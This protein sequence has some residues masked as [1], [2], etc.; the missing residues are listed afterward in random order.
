MTGEQNK[1][2]A[3]LERG[4][5]AKNLAI[6][7]IV[8]SAALSLTVFLVGPIY[9]WSGMELFT[10]GL[11]PF[12]LALIYAVSASV[13]AALYTKMIGQEEE[14]ILLER[15]KSTVASIL[16]ISED[17][18]FTAKHSL[19]NF[20]KYIPPFV[21]VLCFALCTAGIIAFWTNS[22]TGGA[23]AET[24][25][26]LIPKNPINLAFLSAI[27]AV[28]SFIGGIF[29]VGQS[30]VK[31]FRYLRPVGSWLILG[32]TVMFISA[33]CA[34]L[35]HAGSTGYEVIAAK[36]VF[37][38]YALLTAELLI[39]FVVEFYRPRSRD[40]EQRP[41]YESRLLSIFTEPGGVMRNIAESLD[42]QF[43]FKVSKTW[44]YTFAQKHL[45]PALLLW[46]FL[47]WIFT[48][49]AEVNPGEVGI[50][51]RFGAFPKDQSV[52]DPGVHLKLPWPCEKIIRV[53][54]DKVN[55]ITI[56]ATID[57]DKVANAA[58][59]VLWTGSHSSY[60]EE[61]PFLVATRMEGEMPKAPAANKDGESDSSM[62]PASLL[63]VSMPLYF[64]AKK[65]QPYLYAVQ[66]A[67]VSEAI[68]SIG[69][70]EATQ[71]FASTDF[72]KDLSYGREE[73][74]SVLRNLIQEKCDRLNMGVDIIS[75]GMHDA[76]PPVGKA[77]E[78]GS[79]DDTP[80]A[81]PNVAEAF[82]DVVCA[83][84]DATSEK[85]KAE[86]TAVQTVQAASALAMKITADAEA[87]KFNVTEVA[88]TDAFRFVSQ[89][90]AFRNQPS[91]FQLRTYLDFLENDCKEM[92]K[93]VVS[94]G[95][96]TRN[97]MVNLETKPSLDLLDT[98]VSVLGK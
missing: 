60:M 28:F 41:V 88:K 47:F 14:K 5:L 72:M 75:V 95:I 21:A 71:Y 89:L 76:H 53:P 3:A 94:S 91:L 36:I 50:R 81:M 23:T 86:E 80:G 98:D 12:V 18:R 44:I 70:A 77:K 96:D 64:K 97:Y 38:I 42:Y 17:V 45:I 84:E 30:H 48:C 32:A 78:D 57:K 8:L 39:N 49:V 1:L 37:F 63:E 43:G 40:A 52:L 79:P 11:L 2:S 68:L 90:T 9:H 62:L 51:Q 7:G 27:A 93:F 73:V 6:A 87:Y 34:L 15:R 69:R 85:Y 92:R 56:G 24:L 19:A 25:G 67:D 33:I 65:D 35:I 61:A 66:F 13:Y 22:L 59:V 82:Q 29:F 46:A 16:D 26:S 20:E 4:R 10:L 55:A 31:E 58:T 74:V 83:T 54:V